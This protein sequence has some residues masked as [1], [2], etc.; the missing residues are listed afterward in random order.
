MTA[1]TITRGAGDGRDAAEYDEN[2][3]TGEARTHEYGA[4][5]S[6]G[7]PGEGGGWAVNLSKKEE[8]ELWGREKE[9]AGAHLKSK[10]GGAGNYV[11]DDLPIAAVRTLAE[12]TEI[13]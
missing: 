3:G 13:T 8:T 1:G 4:Q 7:G 5:L 9:G 2:G 11:W 10:H 6:H 12:T